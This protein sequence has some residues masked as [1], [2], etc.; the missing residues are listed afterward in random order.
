MWPWSTTS[1][2]TDRSGPRATI[3][4][5]PGACT[6]RTTLRTPRDNEVLPSQGI[7]RVTISWLPLSLEFASEY[8]PLKH[9]ADTSAETTTTS[10][11]RVGYFMSG[12]QFVRCVEVVGSEVSC[13]GS[14]REP[15][16]VPRASAAPSARPPRL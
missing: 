7:S 5:A 16:R 1:V 14:R 8:A 4:P 9:P 2:D 3:F 11:R 15:I 6:Y 10:V 12:F 13:G